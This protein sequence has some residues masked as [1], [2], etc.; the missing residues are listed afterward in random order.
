MEMAIACVG[1]VDMTIP[2]IDEAY[3][4]IHH[5]GSD[6]K[7]LHHTFVAFEQCVFGGTLWWVY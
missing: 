6:E 1:M 2:S 7:T 5:D 4:H 3:T